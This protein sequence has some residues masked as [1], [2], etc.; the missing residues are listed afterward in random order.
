MLRM[1]ERLEVSDEQREKIW[2]VMDKNR[3][4]MRQQM[5]AMMKNRKALQA[6][7]QAEPFDAALVRQLADEHGRIKADMIVLRAQGQQEIKALLTPEQRTRF[8][9]LQ[10]RRRGRGPRA[11]WQ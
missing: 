7:E 5:M 1:M 3:P 10:E 2:A 11:G 6:A 9:G 4:A 8:K